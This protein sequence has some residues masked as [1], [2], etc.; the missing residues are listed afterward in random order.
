MHLTADFTRKNSDKF[1]YIHVNICSTIYP[2][3]FLWYIYHMQI[4]Y[5]LNIP[6]QEVEVINSLDNIF[7]LNNIYFSKTN[8][9]DN[10]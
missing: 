3:S 7:M 10:N 1:D 5:W 2:F 4:L 8:V 6:E 9:F